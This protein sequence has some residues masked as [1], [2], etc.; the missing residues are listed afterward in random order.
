MREQAG[1]KGWK[2]VEL[3]SF[4]PQG[5]EKQVIKSCLGK[6][7]PAGK[8]PFQIGVVVHN[9]GT[10]FAIYEAVVLRKPLYE[11]VMTVTG[12]C[13]ENPKNLLVRIGT[14][15]EDLLQQCGPL[16]REPKRIVMGGPMMGVAQFSLKTPVIKA[17]NGVLFLDEAESRE[18]EETFCVRCGECV[19]YCPVG[20]NPSQISLA[21]AKG[22]LDLAQEY[23]VMDC[24]ECGL[25]A[26]VCPGH[27]NIVQSIKAAKAKLRKR[28]A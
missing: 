23:G 17:T 1:S 10:V 20:L 28:H 12:P 6:E 25:C 15:V 14:L 27:R 16:I 2:V 3:E 9:V 26:Y 19:A 21:L 5:G 18:E 7:V 4:Y 22:R 13:L 8:L 11:R 24:I